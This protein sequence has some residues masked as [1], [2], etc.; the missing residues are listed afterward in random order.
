MPAVNKEKELGSSGRINRIDLWR[1]I[2]HIQRRLPEVLAIAAACVFILLATYRIELPGLYMDEVDFVNAAQGAHDNTM[3]Y[4]RLGSVPLLIMPYL[5]ALKGWLYAPVFRLFGVSALTIRL[6]AI[7]LAAITLLVF[8]QLIRAKLGAVWAVI[9]VC[10]MS[11]D[12]ANLFPSRLDWGPTVLMHFF[13]AAIFALWFSYRDKPRLWK[14]GLICVCAGL[15]F[16]DKFNFIWLVV[17]FVISVSLCYPDSLKSLWVSSSRFVRWAA[18]IVFWIVLAATLYLILAVLHF[19]LT[20]LHTM[21]P[22]GK[23]YGLLGTLSGV[24][25]AN[26]IF[27]DSSGIVTF[28]PFWMIVTDC[29]LALAVL[30]FLTQN[31]EL[32][33]NRKNGY[34]FLL[35]GFLVFL[36]IVVTPEAGG[37]HHHSMIFPLPLLVF[38]FFAQPLHRQLVTKNSRVFATLLLVS[39]A[40]VVFAVNL[41]NTIGYLSRFEANASY[42][43]RWSPE[44]YSLSHYINEHGFEAHDVISVDWGLH[45]QLHALAPKKLRRRMHDYWPMFK[46]LAHKNE[47]RQSG[48]PNYIFPE[49]KSLVLTF[50][51]SKETFPDTRRNFLAALASDPELKWR[52]VK[53]FWYAGEKIYEIYEVDRLIDQ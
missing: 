46:E 43:P 33:E 13:Q 41:R 20:G 29:F 16:F 25:V 3:I 19:R 30:F 31:S 40:T 28:V 10:I 18:V 48:G 22:Q 1:P 42:N 27:G 34:F 15:G 2:L 38:V 11:V 52:L 26:L 51:A 49:G 44:I 45:N 47:E 14:I 36:Q 8:F 21:N 50:A 35:I 7:L 32:R 4:M 9:A 23:W 12:P 24:A 37:P 6:P 5:G 53:E 39:A 17:A